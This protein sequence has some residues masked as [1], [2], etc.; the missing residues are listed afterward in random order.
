M[1]LDRFRD[2]YELASHDTSAP[3]ERLVPVMPR[4]ASPRS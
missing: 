4:R 2:I 3:T 1:M